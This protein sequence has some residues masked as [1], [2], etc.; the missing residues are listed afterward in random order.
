MILVIIS[1]FVWT[2][3]AGAGPERL[4]S[5]LFTSIGVILIAAALA[6]VL[7]FQRRAHSS[8]LAKQFPS[9]LR[10]PILNDA[11]TWGRSDTTARSLRLRCSDIGRYDALSL[12]AD[13]TALRLFAGVW[14]PRLVCAY[15][16]RAIV[17]VGAETYA[18]LLGERT[19]IEISFH[20]IPLDESLFLVVAASRIGFPVAAAADLVGRCKDELIRAIGRTLSS[21]GGDG[22]VSTQQ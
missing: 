16:S 12:V 4:L 20:R 8:Q 10:L 13:E 22:S 3:L 21:N 1:A 5:L 2:A 7:A 17:N 19:S 14:K 15:P 18:T 9:A 6:L 11:Y